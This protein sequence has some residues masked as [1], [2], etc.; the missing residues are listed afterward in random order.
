MEC[1]FVVGQKVVCIKKDPWFNIEAGMISD[2]RTPPKYG[3]IVTI[4][5][6]VPSFDNIG[7]PAIFLVLV[8]HPAEFPVISRR[9]H[10]Q[11]FKPLE[12]KKTDISI[13]EKMLIPAPKKKRVRRR[14][15]EDV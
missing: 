7:Q 14:V 3:D 2:Y 5:E 6:I 13:F 4:Q 10:Q 8:E 9:W 11:W 15:K 1:K 12:E